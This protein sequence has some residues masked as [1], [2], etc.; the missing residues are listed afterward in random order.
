MWTV[1]YIAP[2][3]KIAERIRCRLADEGFLVKVRETKVS[4]QMEILVP[5]SELQEV[6]EALSLILH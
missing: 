3:T 1:I 6:Q 5:E 4:K 2:S